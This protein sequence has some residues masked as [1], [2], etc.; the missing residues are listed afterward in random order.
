MMS[1]PNALLLNLRDQPREVGA[2]RHQT[3]DWVVPAGW[4]TEVLELPA[5]RLV[6]LDVAVT[7]TDGGVYV[8]VEATTDLHGQCVRC[9]DP[10]V[11]P[12]QVVG[13][14]LFTEA[15]HGPAPRAYVDGEIDVEG[16]DFDPDFVI[17]R[18]T[19]D[20]ERL[21]R[22]ALFA[23]APLQPLCDESCLGL[24]EHCGIRLVDA[25]P[26]HHHEFLDPRFA[27][28]QVLLDESKVG[29]TTESVPDNE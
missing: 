10:V 14:E 16:D 8:Q 17:D 29:S 6:P 26:D 9:L 23:D 20:L 21:L 15:S 27:A 19:V 2:Q 4:K 12:T 22:D 7:S 24:C 11:V 1:E 5:G 3:I 13:G 18:D 25:E 28:L